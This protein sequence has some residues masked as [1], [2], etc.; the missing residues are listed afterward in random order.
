MGLI[1]GFLIKLLLQPVSNS[2][3]LQSTVQAKNFSAAE[4][5]LEIAQLKKDKN[6]L[7]E[8]YNNL[9]KANSDSLNS[10]ISKVKNSVA[11]EVYP[12]IA[13]LEKDK[14]ELLEKYDNL[15]EAYYG[16]LNSEIGKV[17]GSVGIGSLRDKSFVYDSVN[18]NIILPDPSKSIFIPELGLVLVDKK[19][20]IASGLKSTSGDAAAALK[21]ENT[22]PDPVLL[23]WIDY[24]GSPVLYKTIMPGEAYQINTYMTHPW[25][26]TDLNG[27]RIGDIEAELAGKTEV[28]PLDH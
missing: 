20:S 7:L 1:A 23:F 11:A 8:L 2:V 24:G 6:E 14:K 21:F 16:S 27:R 13:Q 4:V 10:G 9:L 18:K 17:G 5:S 22:K 3:S 19:E 12:E 25:V 28:I 15:A 26:V